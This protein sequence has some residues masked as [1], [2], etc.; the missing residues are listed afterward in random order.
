MKKIPFTK[1]TFL[2]SSFAPNQFPKLPTPHGKVLPEIALVGRSNVGKSSLINH[3]LRNSSLARTSATPGKTQSINFFSIDDALILVDLP[4]YGYAKVAKK[5]KASWGP[6]IES[7]LKNK[8]QLKLLLLLI[9]VRRDVTEED[10]AILSWAKYRNLPILVVFTKV[11]KLNKK[12]L[13]AHK[14][15]LPIELFTYRNLYFSTKNNSARP[16]L[17]TTLN[18]E[19]LSHGTDP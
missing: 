11:D 19:L 10:V 15:N 1:A 17:I 12:E 14:K 4:G 2:A 18:Q 7:Y 8:S 5:Q 13:E 6:L 3:L 16:E 9:D